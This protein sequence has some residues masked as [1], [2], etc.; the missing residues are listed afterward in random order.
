MLAE[1]WKLQGQTEMTMHRQQCIYKTKAHK[2]WPNDRK[3]TDNCA[4]VVINLLTKRRVLAY[5]F[6]EQ[7]GCIDTW[8]HLVETNIIYCFTYTYHQSYKFI[9]MSVFSNLANVSWDYRWNQNHSWNRKWNLGHWTWFYSQTE[10]IKLIM[11][12][13]L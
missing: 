2:T 7:H 9:T 10:F 1:A 5:L 11:H 8:Y 4:V 6:T 3:T 13:W 12:L